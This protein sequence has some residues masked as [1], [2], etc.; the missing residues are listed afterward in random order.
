MGQKMGQKNV[1]NSNNLLSSFFWLETT[2]TN[3]TI[4]VCTRCLV[5]EIQIFDHFWLQSAFLG[6][7]SSRTE[8]CTAK[9]NGCRLCTTLFY[10]FV[11]KLGKSLESFFRKVQKLQKNGKKAKNADFSNNQQF[12]VN[13]AALRRLST[14]CSITSCQFLEKSLEQF[15][16]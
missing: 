4:A 12:L 9:P 16:R 5:P 1:K 2:P 8:I 6:P 7:N 10:T 15:L 3:V 14:Y 11:K 13:K